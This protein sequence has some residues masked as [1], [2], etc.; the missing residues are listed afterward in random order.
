MARN[1]SKPKQ[2]DIEPSNFVE[3]HFLKT[4]GLYRKNE[5]VI[6]EELQMQSAVRDMQ[7]IELDELGWPSKVVHE[8]RTV[9]HA[10]PGFTDIQT[11]KTVRVTRVKMTEEEAAAYF[12]EKAKD[13]LKAAGK[14]P[15]GKKASGKKAPGKK[16]NH[17]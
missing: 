2:N 7:M 16:A 10:L 15:A 5:N 9:Q 1:I 3:A 17:V 6:I 13:L 4:S 8:E 14:Q 12:Q 11:D